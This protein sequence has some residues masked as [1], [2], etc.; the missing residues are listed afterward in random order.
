M[1]TRLCENAAFHG[2]S[3]GDNDQIVF[4]GADGSLMRVSASG[5]PCETLT[6]SDVQDVRT[7]HHRSPQILPGGKAVLFGIAIPEGTDDSQIAVLDLDSREYRVLD[8]RGTSA[9]FVPSGHIAYARSSTI[10]AVP[11]DIDRLIATGPEVLA[12]DRVLWGEGN[13]ATDYTFSDT[14]TL[15]YTSAETAHRRSPG[16]IG[17]RN[18]STLTRTGARVRQRDRFTG[19]TSCRNFPHARRVGNSDHRSGARD[20]QSC[21]SAR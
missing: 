5:G 6:T 7:G 2:G 14:G 12:V 1:S 19:R 8:Q 9:R 3:W 4:S 17:R 13:G 21:I 18:Y 16:S 20:S 15:V 11:F 10:F